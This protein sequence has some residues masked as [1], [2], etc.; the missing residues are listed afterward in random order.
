M[1]YKSQIKNL[2]E[3]YQKLDNE[4][5]SLLKSEDKDQT[6]LQDLIGKKSK[7]QLDIRKLQ[8]LQWEEE[9]DR[10]NFEDYR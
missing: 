9:H 4:V 10:V 1:P 6:K 3:A 2:Q 7:I 8:K 5:F